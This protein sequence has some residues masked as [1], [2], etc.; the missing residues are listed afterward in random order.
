MLKSAENK[1]Q[2]ERTER[3]TPSLKRVRA[4]IERKKREKKHEKGGGEREDE[5]EREGSCISSTLF[6]KGRTLT[7]SSWE[8]Q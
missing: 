4:E 3:K 1:M 8:A 2:N 7:F 5:R 6:W